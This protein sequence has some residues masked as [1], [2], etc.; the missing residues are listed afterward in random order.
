MPLRNEGQEEDT[1]KKKK[2][3][4]GAVD[5]SYEPSLLSGQPPGEVRCG[6]AQGIGLL[7]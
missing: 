7:S 1:K 4:R 6:G 2:G 5:P 3:K